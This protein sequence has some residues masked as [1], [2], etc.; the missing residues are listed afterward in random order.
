MLRYDL[1]TNNPET[2]FTGTD[3]DGMSRLRTAE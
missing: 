1:S 2:S 3:A